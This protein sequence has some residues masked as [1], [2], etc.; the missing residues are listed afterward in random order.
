MKKHT[1]MIVD[2]DQ[3]VRHRIKE[4]IKI[5][6]YH[7]VFWECSNGLEAVKYINDLEP[8]LLFI[9]VNV[10]GISG[11]E[12]IDTITHIP[13]IIF[14]SVCGKDAAKAFEY[15]AIDYLIKP[16]TINRIQ[17]SLKRFDEWI[18]TSNKNINQKHVQI[19]YTGRILVEKGFQLT[20]IPVNK[21]TH[22][23][24]DKDYTWIYT[25][26]GE[27]YLSSYGIGQLEHRLDPQYFVRIHRS[28]IVNI[29]HIKN[30]LRDLNKFIVSLPND[31]QINVSRNYLP[32][33]KK[34]IF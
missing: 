7:C 15:Q 22:L 1:V 18:G 20:S 9:D 2:R 29:D 32:V 14:T 24:A 31:I 5:E 13:S 19:R 3:S 34:F 6:P 11:F 17:L 26:N 4:Y 27:V 12:V 33:I 25:L 16:L 8:D 30:L 21:V 10:P 28:Y 23:K